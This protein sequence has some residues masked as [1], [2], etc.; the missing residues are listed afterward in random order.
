MGKSAEIGAL[1]G[2]FSKLLQYIK[3]PKTGKIPPSY[4]F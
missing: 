4:D 1:R 2:N 3:N